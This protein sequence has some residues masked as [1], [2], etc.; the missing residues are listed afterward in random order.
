[1]KSSQPPRVAKPERKARRVSFAADTK[2]DASRDSHAYLRSPH[3]PEYKPGT[4]ASS[5]NRLPQD[6][7]FVSDPHFNCKQLKIFSGTSE[8]VDELLGTF[9][10]P[11]R[12]EGILEKHRYR[13]E[14]L[15]CLKAL[16][17]NDG[18]RFAR[19]LKGADWILVCLQDE[20]IYDVILHNTWDVEDLDSFNDKM[21]VDADD[22]EQSD[23]SLESE[24]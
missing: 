14:I 10:D 21:E 8:E 20:Q 16:Y 3:N 23:S 4:F 5:T 18:E 12:N 2:F 9:E 11:P 19:D 7:S 17:K 13:H 24:S 6:T 15:M 22:E 1:M